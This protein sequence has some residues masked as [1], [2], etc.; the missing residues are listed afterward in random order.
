MPPADT[1]RYSRRESKDPVTGRRWTQ[2]TSGDEYC[3]PLYFFGPTVTA[4]GALLLF[5]RYRDDEVQIWRLELATGEATRLTGAST[6][7]GLWRPWD[8]PRPAR[9]VRELFSAFSPGSEEMFYFDGNLLRAVHVRTLA[10]RAVHEV[11]ADRVP[12]GLPG[13]SPDGRHFALLHCDR[14]WWEESTRRGPPPRHEARGCRLDVVETATGRARNLVTMNAWLTHANFLDHERIVFSNPPTECGKMMTDLRGGWY[15]HLRT[16][17]V[18][19]WVANHYGVTRRGLMYETVSPMPF[20]IMGICDPSTYACRDFMT[21]CPMAHLGQDAEGRLWFGDSYRPEPPHDRFLA[22]FPRLRAG[23]VNPFA[24]LTR[25]FQMHGRNQRS[26]VHAVLMP[27]RRQI[28][29]TGPDDR[30]RTNHMFL[31]DVSDL[32]DAE[33]RLE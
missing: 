26:H 5:H 19:G 20:G 7:N 31:L 8:E 29:F 30:T 10:D 21:A 25:G 1:V 32:A 15:V 24:A 23:E 17:T 2:L 4:D 27:D 28:L 22:W 13:A 16:Q 12:C 11:P 3:Y 9:G 14:K 18:E 6:P 33:T